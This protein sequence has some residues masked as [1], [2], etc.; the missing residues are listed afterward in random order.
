MD[1]CLGSKR[2]D[3]IVHKRDLEIDAIKMNIKYER[4][5]NLHSFCC[6]LGAVKNIYINH[7]ETPVPIN[8]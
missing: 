2:T 3:E 7:N 4:I 1:K 5:E 8:L 6:G